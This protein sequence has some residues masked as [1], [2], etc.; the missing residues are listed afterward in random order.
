MEAC[1]S[2]AFIVVLFAGTTNGA[3]K[4]RLV[5]IAKMAEAYPSVGEYVF[6]F[7]VCCRAAFKTTKV[8]KT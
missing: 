8:K 2:S 7:A 1:I 3:C 4:L 5:E 6:R